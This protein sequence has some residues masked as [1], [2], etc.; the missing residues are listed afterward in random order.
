MKAL[1]DAARVGHNW[2]PETAGGLWV[3]HA[4]AKHLINSKDV[5]IN[6]GNDLVYAAPFAD[7]FSRSPFSVLQPFARGHPFSRYPCTFTG[8]SPIR[9]F[10]WAAFGAEVVQNVPHGRSQDNLRRPWTSGGN[11]YQ[12]V[13]L[14]QFGSTQSAPSGGNFSRGMRYLLR[15]QVVSTS[16]VAVAIAVAVYRSCRR[17]Y[18]S[19][20]YYLSLLLF[21]CIALAIAVY[22]YCHCCPSLLLSLLSLLPLLSIVIAVAGNSNS[23][24]N[25]NS[26]SN[27][28]VAN[29]PPACRANGACPQRNSPSGLSH[30]TVPKGKEDLWAN[31]KG[32]SIPQPG[33][34]AKDE[35]KFFA[36]NKWPNI[37][38]VHAPRTMQNIYEQF[39]TPHW[40]SMWFLREGVGRLN[41]LHDKTFAIS[42]ERDSL[43]SP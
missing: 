35:W 24:S 1:E 36:D 14:F 33:V 42:F 8:F 25:S 9:C 40:M 3:Y 5:P 28:A 32:S 13:V 2:T 4:T 43:E 21:L 27:A 39:T 31:I 16:Q 10:L 17:S 26:N 30:Y 41:Q 23:D 11:Q 6:I 12:G 18:R 19:C 22:C 37:I 7:T 34:D 20:R 38:H 29:L 15:R